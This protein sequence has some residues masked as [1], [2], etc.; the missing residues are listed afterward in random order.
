[1]AVRTQMCC[2]CID[3]EQGAKILAWL[4]IFGSTMAG[5]FIGLMKVNCNSSLGKELTEM[6]DQTLRNKGLS[7]I[8]EELNIFLLLLG[9]FWNFAAIRM[10]LGI[11][12]VF[13]SF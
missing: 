13:I 12:E 4:T 1:M 6:M 9:A 3:L 5:I 8:V 2:Q 11:N 7:E 10:L